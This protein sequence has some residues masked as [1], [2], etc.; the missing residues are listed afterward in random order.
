VVRI[1]VADLR[2]VCD[3]LLSHLE[4]QG[5]ESVE[6]PFD[7]YWDIPEEGRYKPYQKPSDHTLGQ[8][9]DDW[10]ELRKVLDGRSE[11]I[12]YHFVWLATILRAI[13]EAVVS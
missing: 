6:L 4:E 3:R 13:G 2:S 11:P 1:D 5:I 12:S 10:S 9:T 7:Y 8:L